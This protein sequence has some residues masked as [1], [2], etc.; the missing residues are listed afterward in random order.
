MKTFYTY[1]ST[2]LFLLLG[3]IASAQVGINTADPH[4]SAALEIASDTSGVLIPRMTQAQ[5][6]AITNPAEGLLTY[7]KDLNQFSYFDGDWNNV[8]SD[9]QQRK[10][11]VLIEKESDFPD[12]VDG[13]ITLDENLSYEISGFIPLTNSIDMNNATIYGRFAQ[14]DVLF[15]DSESK[16]IFKGATGGTVRNLSLSRK[17]NPVDKSFVGTAK[18]FDLDAT[19]SLGSTPQ[20]L[21]LQ[22]V[23]ING[24]NDVGEVDGY[25]LV[26][27]DVVQYQNCQQGVSYNS[28]GYLLLNATGWLENN[29]GTYETIT[30]AFQLIQK[31]SGFMNVVAGNT[32]FD[33]TGVTGVAG[34]A[35][36]EGCVFLG[37]GERAVGAG[38]YPGYNFR[39]FWT[40]DSP[41]INM[42]SDDVASGN[43]Y[44]DGGVTNGYAFTCSA[45]DVGI[46]KKLTSTSTAY[47]TESNN[48]FRFAYP[49]D[50]RLVYEG[51]KTR[52]FQLNASLSVRVNQTGEFYGFLVAVNDEVVT[53]SN[54]IFR[55][56]NPSDIQNV[57]LN[58]IVTLKPGDYIELYLQRITGNTDGGGN[59]VNSTVA[60][61]SENLSIK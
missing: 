44:Y 9:E 3:A 15:A 49:T 34:S 1:Y 51:I 54:S 5:I 6:D 11:T 28:G 27:F 36:L 2:F 14:K 29:V 24:M 48:L 52:N 13:V 4:A 21:V 60:I 16:P 32:G 61:F 43:Y 58:T 20:N 59:V 31:Q 8:E 40:V 46:P 42:E 23:I 45:A 7:N 39:N 19:G 50:N 17:I 33:V 35:V 55:V 10:T 38:T 56:D 12:P 57:A 47:T 25:G 30:G 22:S 18:A 41:G 37:A 53:E 26:F